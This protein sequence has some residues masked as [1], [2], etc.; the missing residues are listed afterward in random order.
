[1]SEERSFNRNRRLDAASATGLRQF[2][3]TSGQCFLSDGELS[4]A[5]RVAERARQQNLTDAIPKSD[6]HKKPGRSKKK[7][8]ETKITVKPRKRQQLSV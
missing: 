3:G 2:R 6:G 5:K 8:P 1:M 4:R 7:N